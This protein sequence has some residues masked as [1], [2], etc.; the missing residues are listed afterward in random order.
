GIGS[1]AQGINMNSGLMVAST[2]VM[3]GAVAWAT[4]G[5]FLQGAM[6]GMNIGFLNHAM[7]DDPPSVSTQQEGQDVPNMLPEVVVTAKRL[8]IETL[9]TKIVYVGTL[10]NK[11]RS[12]GT[13]T[14]YYGDKQVYLCSAVSGASNCKS[15]TIPNGDW[16]VVSITNRSEAMF[17]SNGVGFTANIEPDPFYDNRAGRNRQYIRIHPAR[18]N[19]TN[20]CI[21]LRANRAQL[22]RARDLIRN[23]L[24]R[25]LTIKLHV[26]INSN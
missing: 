1:Y 16:D 13:Y 15:Y 24:K 6:Q 5:D 4:G 14:M 18:S 23:S 3:G 10:V 11:Y 2:T 20:G 7:H 9:I 22:I 17:T 26:Q 21:G 25:G 12:Q 19:G 8:S